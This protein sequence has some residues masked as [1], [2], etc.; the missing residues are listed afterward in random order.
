VSARAKSAVLAAALVLCAGP[1]HAWG[2]SGHRVVASIAERY[3]TRQAREGIARL[4]PEG[5]SLA[6]IASWADQYRELCANT[7]GWHYV[8]IPIQEPGFDWE[9]FCPRDKSCVIRAL[10][11]AS[12]LL[13]DV[14]RS[15]A[16]RRYA[17]HLVVHFTGDLHQPLH[18]GDR[19]DRGG[20]DLHVRWQGRTMSLHALW[21]VALIEWTQR[22]DGDYAE[23]L[24]RGLSPGLRLS[25]SQGPISG[26]A[27]QAKRAA[28][29][30]YEGLREA[31][32]DQD[33]VDL[34]EHY[35]R[36]MLPVVDRQLARAGVRLAAL[37][38][39]AFE[40]PGPAVS[41]SD[42]RELLTCEPHA[43]PAPRKD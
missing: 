23:L 36:A 25:I 12:A 14:A 29:H 39:S 21:D 41:E 17:L 20:N 11:Q 26:W 24:A 30:A 38:N 32:S 35:A 28:R 22:A 16:E 42:V 2:G 40:R 3:L 43:R 33:P 7:G 9:R 1:L 18:S 27:I 31:R 8:N 10:E 13:A 37:L 4:L 19:T 5:Q 6:D 34:G 15:D